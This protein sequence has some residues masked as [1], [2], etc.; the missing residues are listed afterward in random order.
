MKKIKTDK[1]IAIYSGTFDPITIG[2]LDI[3][4]QAL[5]VFDK[6]LIAV[7][8]SNAKKPMFSIED[9]VLFIK[10]SISKLDNVKVES[11]SNLLVDFMAKK[12]INTIIRG[13]R[14]N[15]DFE[16]EFQISYANQ[17]LN[18]NINTIFLLPKLK[19][20]FIS[21]SIVR[22]LIRFNGKFKHLIPKEI[23]KQILGL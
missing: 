9:R 1:K 15:I 12:K 23:Y 5:K 6:V 16:Y 4:K 22:E 11:F 14:T 10:K 8:D 2:H 13:L 3:L 18:S 7:A 19:N 17:S 20:S 21:S